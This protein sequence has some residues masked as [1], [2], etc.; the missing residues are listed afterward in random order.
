MG[1][2]G[3]NAEVIKG[4]FYGCLV[5]VD[6]NCAQSS[7]R[8]LT[9]KF[10]TLNDKERSANL[11]VGCER[12]IRKDFIK[13]EEHNEVDTV[14]SAA[15]VARQPER[16]EVPYDPAT[17]DDPQFQAQSEEQR[18]LQQIAAE[19]KWRRED[20]IRRRQMEELQ[21][22]REERVKAIR[23]QNKAEE[24]EIRR[25]YENEG[26]KV[27][28]LLRRAEERAR[29]LGK[30]D[31][32]E[33]DSDPTALPY[34]KEASS[35]AGV[36]ATSE[37]LQ[38][39]AHQGAAPTADTETVAARQLRA[40]QKWLDDAPPEGE[41]DKGATVDST[42]HPPGP[43]SR[44][45]HWCQRVGCNVQF[46]P[47]D[48]GDAACLYHPGSPVFHDGIK[49]WSCCKKQS[50]DFSAFMSLPGC[51][52]GCHTNVPQNMDPSPAPQQLPDDGVLQAPQQGC[53]R[54]QNGFFCSDHSYCFTAHPSSQPA[55][56]PPGDL[57][58]RPPKEAAIRTKKAAIP[59]VAK[60]TITE[61]PSEATEL[62]VILD[63]VQT[64]GRQ[65]CGEKFSERENHGSACRYHPGP[66]VFHERQKGWSCCN[67]MVYDFDEFLRIPPCSVARHC[68]N[69]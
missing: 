51:V 17:E 37:E 43:A 68:A 34:G 6:H 55:A 40:A 21:H 45:L 15:Q 54:C 24:D 47:E 25:R 14:A 52:R 48:N 69:P 67:V 12:S 62:Q 49:K 57:A 10:V 53:S 1:A 18:F 35:G 65:G 33:E 28:A 13:L 31:V 26:A 11:S 46:S 50:H 5:E 66:P 30:E 20:E 29:Q 27:K 22:E 2:M 32:E 9:V 61:I 60:L 58:T 3:L 38:V 16:M 41:D 23:S 42:P 7:A 59:Q 8:M 63:T 4:P 64:C 39:T 56:G 44:K 19:E 36:S